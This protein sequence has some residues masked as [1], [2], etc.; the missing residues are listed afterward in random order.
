MIMRLLSAL[1]LFVVGVI[2]IVYSLMVLVT[3]TNPT[4]QD[5]AKGLF[6]L[7]AGI[8]VMGMFFCLMAGIKI[9]LPSISGKNDKR[10]NKRG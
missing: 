8:V 5:T 9:R 4:M 10:D 1:Y 7:I 3:T 2:A 6:F